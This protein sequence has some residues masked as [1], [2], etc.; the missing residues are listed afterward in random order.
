MRGIKDNR[1]KI[2]A[3]A[4]GCLLLILFVASF[5]IMIVD[6]E[7][8][9]LTADTKR[10]KDVYTKAPR[11]D[12]LD[13][14]GNILATTK[15]SFAVQVLADE[16]HRQDSERVNSDFKD[17]I[18]F[19]EEDGVAYGASN[20]IDMYSLVYENKEDYLKEKSLAQEKVIDLIIENK[21]VKEFLGL[22]LDGQYRFSNVARAI[23]VL[24]RR[25][26]E[27]IP[28]D[29]NLE[30]GFEL[31]YKEDLDT[32]NLAANPLD[33][34]LEEITDT[35][36]ILGNIL[37]HP[38]SR[39]LAFEMLEE[40]NLTSN[41][42]LE[43][44]TFKDD[45]DALHNKVGLSK[46]F[47]DISLDSEAKDDFVAISSSTLPILLGSMEPKTDKT[48]EIVPAKILIPLVEEALGREIGLG[49]EVEGQSVNIFYTSSVQTTE[50]PVEM[51]ARLAEESGV[52]YDFLTSEEIKFLAQDANTKAG[53]TPHISVLEW[54]YVFV[55]NKKDMLDKY[56][57]KKDATAEEALDKIAVFY[58]IQASNPYEKY[59]LAGLNIELESQGYM[60]YEPI[61]L[62]YG[63]KE[64]TV[65][66]IEEQ[67]NNIGIDVRQLPIRYYPGSTRAAHVLGYMGKISQPNE[68]QTFIKEGGYQP[69]DLIGKTGVEESY[70]STLRGKDGKQAVE[71]DSV[72]NTTNIIEETPPVK[73]NS[74]YLTLDLDLQRVAEDSLSHTLSQLRDGGNFYSKWGEVAL[75]GNEAEARPHYNATSGSVVVLDVKSG[76]VLALANETTYDPNLFATGISE[77]DWASLFPEDEDNPLADRPLL[78]VAM[79]TEVSPG[80]IFKLVPALAGLEKG[81]SP[82]EAI[83]CTGYID[84]GDTRFG[85]WIY[86]QYGGAHGY[87][88][89]I[90]AIR[91]SCNYYFYGLALG[92]NPQTGE[93]VSVQ[94]T[95]DDIREY[96]IKLGLDE[97]TGIEIN[98]PYEASGAMPSPDDKRLIIKYLLEEFLEE[99]L[100]SYVKETVS[101]NPDSKRQIISAILGLVDQGEMD[102]TSFEK[103]LDEIGIDTEKMFED[104]GETITERLKYTYFDLAQWNITDMLNIV[105]GQ[106]QNAYTPL[107]MANYVSTIANGGYKNKVTVIDK[108]MS[109]DSQATLLENEARSEKIELN[110][111]ENLNYIKTGMNEASHFGSIENVFGS[112]PVEVGLK[113]GT[114][115]RGGLNPETGQGFDDYSW[116]IAFAPYDD[117]QIAI[118]TLLYQ[119]GS[120]SNGSAIVREVVGQYLGLEPDYPAF[121]YED[122]EKPS[123]SDL[124]DIDNSQQIEESENNQEILDDFQEEGAEPMEYIEE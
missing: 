60:A 32:D 15:N 44:F 21:L 53:I 30:D 116:M 26:Q 63:L 22:K 97:P 12:I 59:R 1:F 40:K 64:E 87:E 16:L 42:G 61:T 39:K 54:D 100:E 11:G 20:P 19:L 101:I 75:R 52:L 46:T 78:N 38:I 27:E 83:N 68:I 76:E 121:S 56:G 50:T 111:Y 55:K 17:L 110:N 66:K 105:I 95:V 117:P 96:A 92:E 112:F 65:A 81:M 98:I 90:G 82:Y 5:K 37:E 9:R 71:V 108:V 62:T 14:N 109:H 29:I 123:M 31:K 103:E 58:K 35:K 36:T 49:V 80:S 34:L 4:L 94:L 57:A 23:N 120:G 77:S 104:T 25:T 8:Y 106:G 119:A 72:G 18:K 24:E 107:Q 118:C 41:I 91:D 74:L 86:N 3:G 33:Y 102:Y 70:E 88:D 10:I 73:G 124:E 99:N 93:G 51:L 13:R 89:V 45:L 85:C 114:A 67:I 48:E 6:G 2:I 28:I 43:D 115:E 69:G 47:K 7:E 79:Q 84:I 113:T 122:L